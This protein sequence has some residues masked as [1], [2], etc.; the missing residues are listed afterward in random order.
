MFG[1]KY[2][3]VPLWGW[4]VGAVVLLV[5]YNMYF[6]K[7]TESFAQSDKNQIK[8]KDI[9]IYNYNTEWC[10]WSKKFQPEWN[11]FEQMSN[12][13]NVKAVDVKC[14][15]PE[16]ESMC[17]EAGIEG[18]PTVKIDVDGKVVD[19]HGERSAEAIAHVVKNL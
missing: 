7:K 6:V 8:G 12:T 4:I 10:G 14:D 1:E 13:L 2:F 5:I 9:T 3:N 18:F 16:N 17:S 19:Y 15:K 11:K